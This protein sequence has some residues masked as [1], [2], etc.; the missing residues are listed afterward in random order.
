MIRISKLT[1]YA[2]VILA[3]IANAPT[4]LFQARE[5][6]NKTHIALPTISKLL[7]NLTKKEFLQSV[8]GKQG[9]YRL[10]IDPKQIS[11]AS[12]I[13]ALEGPLAITE[14]SKGRHFCLTESNCSIRAPWVYI[15]KVMTDA[16]ES[17]TLADLIDPEFPNSFPTSKQL[18][19][20]QFT[21]QQS[22]VK[23]LTVKPMNNG[24]LL[25]VK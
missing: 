20:E 18:T 4:A 21:A 11:V 8:R 5:V 17:I 25:H 10:N 6:A 2:L 13:A 22:T 9:G 1:D 3:M 15:N 12:L 14:C 19:A 24:E 23:Y 16:L 7:K